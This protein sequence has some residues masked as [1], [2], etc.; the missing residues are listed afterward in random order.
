MPVTYLEL[1]NFKSYGG[2]QKIGP[3]QSFTSIIGPNGS[4]K[5]NCMD[6]LSFVLGVQSRDLRSSQMKDLIFRPPTTTGSK[7]RNNKL[8]ASAAIYF[9]DDNNHDQDDDI[10]DDNSDDDKDESDESSDP[11][12]K[13]T[14]YN[15][16]TR[17]KTVSKSNASNKVTTKFQRTIHPNG[18]GDYR[19][20][21]KVVTYKQ[22]EDKLASIGVLVKARNFLVFQGDVESLARKSPTEFVELLEQISQSAELKAPYE[23]ALLTKEE[24]EAASLFS[25]NKQKGMKGERRLLKEQKEEAERFDQL[26]AN[27]QHLLTDFYLWQIHH[28]EID[29]KEREQHLAELQAEAEEKE[30]I[31]RSHTIALKKAKKQASSARRAHQKADKERVELASKADQLEPSLI[32]VEEEIKTFQK[33]IAKDKSQIGKHK[34][35]ASTQKETLKGLDTAIEETQKNLQGLQDEYDTAKQAALP[36]DQPKLSQSQEE[37]YERIREAAAAAS[38]HPRG[39]LQQITRQIESARGAAAESKRQLQETQT[40]KNNLLRV[41]KELQVRRDK[42]ANS[43]K[44]TEDDRKAAQNELREAN[45]QNETANLRR[46]MIDIELDKIN[47]TLRD[48]RDNRRKTRDEERLQDAIK[49]LKLHFKGVYGRL[50]D[51]CRPTQRRYNLAVTV[52]A[53]KDMDALV[54]DTR[55]TGIECIKYLRENRIGTATFLPLDRVQIP[56]RESTERIRARLAQDGRFRLAADVIT[57]DPAIQK[58]VLYAVDNTVVCDKLDSARQLCF[59]NDYNHRRAGSNSNQLPSIKAVTLCG[60]VISKAGTMTGGVTNEGSNKAG[61]WDDQAMEELHQKKEKLEGERNDLDR[62]QATGR[63]SIGRSNR[64]EELRNNYDSLNNRAE[65]SKSDMEFTRKALAEKNTLLKSIARRIPQI[66]TKLSELEDEIKRLDIEKEKAIALVKT[67]EDEHLGPFLTATGLTDLQAYEQATREA[68]D[69]FNKNKRVLLEH[70][71]QLEEQKNYESNRDFKKPIIAVEKRLKT[72]QK[73]LND[74]KKHQVQLKK[75]GKDAKENLEEAEESVIQ[76]QEE[77]RSTEEKAKLFQKDFKQSQKERN[78]VSKLVASEE[79]A[80]EQLRGRLAENL[81]RAR[82]EEVFLPVIGEDGSPAISGRTTRSGRRIGTDDKEDEKEENEEM[83]DTQET[84]NTI[85]SATQYSQEDNPK[86]VADKNEAERLDFSKLRPDLKERLSDR[87]VA[88]VKKDFEEKRMKIDAE[89][90]GIVPNMKAHEAFS[91]ITEKLRGSDSDYQHAKEKSRKAAAEFLKMKKKRT[92][93][94]LEAFNHIDKALKTIYTDMT[95]SSK[96]P[97]GGNAYLT[98][99]DTEEP[100]KGGM[101]FNAMPPMKRFRDMYQLSGGEKTV[102]SL[103]LLFAIHSYHPAPFFVMD[104]VDAALD[105]INLRKVCNYIQQRS[106]VDF[107]CIVISLK[108]MFYE[109]SQSLVGICKDVGTNSSRTLTLDLT[110]Y[111]KRKQEEVNE[112]TKTVKRKARSD[113]GGQL[114]RKRRTSNSSATITTH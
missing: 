65:Y 100:F 47:A 112:A 81:Q 113:G 66:E 44:K 84:D 62:S 1:E 13:R 32:R 20:N 82:L 33:Q 95:K 36:E 86:V 53:G 103:A 7:T 34:E 9:E 5:S 2:L 55:A 28:M 59:G 90:E 56:S 17:N 46:G 21:N 106:Q 41:Q 78:A 98:L 4:G 40:Q 77:E 58:A 91:A 57:C 104:E 87:E 97:L 93:K 109:R 19:I 25:Y 76:A 29:R 64:I 38:V 72:H 18:T 27:R 3:F 43:I 70:I 51:L 75:E 52:A 12:N 48:V 74:A 68:R 42:I 96:H 102:A 8:T 88:Q 79:S 54:V 99:D 15:I 35:K 111:D 26:L 73:K 85:P 114:S 67:V 16:R 30:E 45:E 60:A 110:A 80:L 31:E 107:Q 63:Q 105:N 37:E 49:A 6:A 94:F 71:T 69:E 10:D 101:K 61:R 50:V 89:I 108:D 39:K 22:Y 83:F 11:T 24:A 14:R 23:A 92:K